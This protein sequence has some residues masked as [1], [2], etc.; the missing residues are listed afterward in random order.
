MAARNVKQVAVYLTEA[1]RAT[2]E[3]LHEATRI[4]RT[5][6]LRE[7]VEDLFTKY[8]ATLKQGRKS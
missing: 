3:R 4:P 8:A 1:Q 5:V 7:A 2:L 6:L